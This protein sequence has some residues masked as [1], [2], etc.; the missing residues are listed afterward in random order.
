MAPPQVD[1]GPT[2]RPS[3]SLSPSEVVS[4]QFKALSRGRVGQDRDGIAGIETWSKCPRWQ[5]PSFALPRVEAR[6]LGAQPLPQ[7]LELAA[8]KAADSAAVDLPGIDAALEFVAP[9]IV[10]QRGTG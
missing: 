1:I 10:E 7:V 5:C 9:N 6:P 3:L 4:A 8:S 2:V